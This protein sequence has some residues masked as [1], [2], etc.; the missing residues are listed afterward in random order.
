M[1]SCSLRFISNPRVVFRRERRRLCNHPRLSSIHGKV[2][3]ALVPQIPSAQLG[4]A[5][6]LFLDWSMVLFTRLPSVSIRFVFGT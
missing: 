6:A 5:R 1:A 3:P 2:R 4:A